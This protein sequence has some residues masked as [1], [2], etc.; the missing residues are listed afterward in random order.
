[1]WSSRALV[2]PCV[3]M[4]VLEPPYCTQGPRVPASCMLYSP[5]AQGSLARG[6]TYTYCAR[7]N[8][9]LR[10]CRMD[11]V[12]WHHRARRHFGALSEVPQQLS[13]LRDALET[14]ESDVFCV[15]A[16]GFV[17]M[18]QGGREQMESHPAL[19]AGRGSNPGLAD[20]GQICCSHVCVSP[21]TA[22]TTCSYRRWSKPSS[23]SP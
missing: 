19:S 12:P 10:A 21:C 8:V 11:S 9:P 22:W 16:A 23:R 13:A 4:C 7:A 2:A 18:W 15:K 6:S 1:M 17:E 20:P 5:E 14:G 3:D